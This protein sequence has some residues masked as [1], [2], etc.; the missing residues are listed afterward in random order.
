MCD[1]PQNEQPV[2]LKNYFVAKIRINRNI[3]THIQLPH[4]LKTSSQRIVKLMKTTTRFLKFK[5]TNF[6]G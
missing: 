6:S 2:A 5:Y 4:D 1:H 3:E